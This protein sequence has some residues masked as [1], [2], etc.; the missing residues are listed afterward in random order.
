MLFE[1]QLAVLRCLLFLCPAGV[2]TET[3]DG[4]SV[5]AWA[6]KRPGG[7]YDFPADASAGGDIVQ[8]AGITLEDVDILVAAQEK[9]ARI[10]ADARREAEGLRSEKQSEAETILLRQQQ[11]AERLLSRHADD[12]AE[13]AERTDRASE[14]AP[15]ER[16]D[17]VLG[18]AAVRA[19]DLLRRQAAAAEALRAAEESEAARRHDRVE[20]DST[21]ILMEAHREAA[22]V[23]LRARMV[24][25]DRRQSRKAPFS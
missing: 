9:A 19:E 25:E 7:G 8:N 10:L 17:Q 14:E 24:V 21:E 20:H 15:L 16:K 18:E 11:V 23:L 5:G 12:A 1:Y 13:A 6:E 2:P 22:A 3:W 4:T